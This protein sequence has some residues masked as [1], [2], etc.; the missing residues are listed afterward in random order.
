M[1]TA[2]ACSRMAFCFSSADRNETPH[3]HAKRDKVVTVA[4]LLLLGRRPERAAKNGCGSAGR[5]RPEFSVEIALCFALKTYW[6]RVI[7]DGKAEELSV[8]VPARL[9]PFLRNHL[10]FGT[11]LLFS[12]RSEAGPLQ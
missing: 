9:R 7:L 4:S 12:G 8:A 5:E 3:V 2:L 11:Q 6:F 10:V 1:P